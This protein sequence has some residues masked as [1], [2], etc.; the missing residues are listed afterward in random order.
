MGRSEKEAS[1]GCEA[2][3]SRLRR[4]DS[5]RNS[6][7]IDEGQHNGAEAEGTA[8]QPRPGLE[9]WSSGV[10]QR[11]QG[12]LHLVTRAPQFLPGIAGPYSCSQKLTSSERFSGGHHEVV[13][14]STVKDGLLAR[15]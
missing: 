14:R 6:K 4:E 2:R 5:G 7:Q 15:C 9:E 11:A 12:K 13:S 10:T 3:G 1:V 8:D